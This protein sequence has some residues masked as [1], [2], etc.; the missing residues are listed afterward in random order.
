[1]IEFKVKLDMQPRFAQ[2]DPFAPGLRADVWM[3]A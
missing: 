3:A 1:M 2:I